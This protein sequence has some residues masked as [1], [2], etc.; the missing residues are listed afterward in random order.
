MKRYKVAKPHLIP[1]TN[2]LKNKPGI[3]NQKDLDRFELLSFLARLDTTPD[4]DL[5]T[6]HLKKM[7]AHTL[8]D[9]YDWAGEFRNIPTERG[10]SVFCRPEFIAQ[11]T[12]KI[13]IL[14]TLSKLKEMKIKKFAEKLAEIVG[15]LN[16]IHPFLDGNG[17]VIR[18]YA[19]KLRRP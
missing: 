19:Q 18:V 13:T 7:H 8:Q 9:V 15:E 11:E 10:T 4:G 16:A 12:D 2:V 6:N 5:S 3:T 1:G 17:R 14:I